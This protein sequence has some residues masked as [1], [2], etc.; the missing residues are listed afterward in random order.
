MA[1]SGVVRNSRRGAERAKSAEPGERVRDSGDV[2]RKS[3][4][5][6][7]CR[8]ETE[9]MPAN[10]VSNSSAVRHRTRIAGIARRAIRV[11]CPV[12]D[13]SAGQN[14]PTCGIRLSACTENE[15]DPLRPSRTPRLCVDHG[16]GRDWPQCPLA[17]LNSRQRIPPSLDRYPRFTKNHQRA[18]R[19]K[20]R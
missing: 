13:K 10:G 16:P 6:R 11:A 15:L 18:A 7:L 14:R 3:S 12:P 5:G 20:R 19:E 8:S 1:E 17:P 9:A 2:P 4:V